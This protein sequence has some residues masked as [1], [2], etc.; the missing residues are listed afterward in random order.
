MAFST[1]WFTTPIASRC[2]AI[3][4]ARNVARRR[5]D[6]ARRSFFVVRR[7]QGLR[8]FPRP[9][10]SATGALPPLRS[11]QLFLDEDEHLFHNRSASVATLRELLAFGPEC[12]SRS[13]RNQ[14]SPS[15][16]S[17]FARQF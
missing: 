5:R 15:P 8:A 17:S 16:E 9:P 11:G 2:A 3:P 7:G 12:R 14:R 1:G 6:Y 4:C 10:F 13:L